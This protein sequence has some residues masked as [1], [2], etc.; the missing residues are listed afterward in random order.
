[1]DKNLFIIVQIVPSDAYNVIPF[2]YLN[3]ITLSGIPPNK[4][5]LKKGAIVMLI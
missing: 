1:M 2:E 5:T 4:L 3:S